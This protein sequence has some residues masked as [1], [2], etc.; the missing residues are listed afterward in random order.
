[1]PGLDTAEGAALD[2]NVAHAWNVNA[3]LEPELYV[4]VTEE[5]DGITAIQKQAEASLSYLIQWLREEGDRTLSQAEAGAGPLVRM[6]DEVGTLIEAVAAI[7]NEVTQLQEQRVGRHDAHPYFDSMT[8]H[9]Y[10]VP[11][12]LPCSANLKRPRC[13]HWR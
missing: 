6:Q 3:K 4:K 5:G 9:R 7:E 2:E 13:K 8:P 11:P 1:M 10:G 12:P